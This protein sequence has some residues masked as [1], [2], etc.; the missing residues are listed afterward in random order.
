MNKKGTLA[1]L[2]SMHGQ[3]TGIYALALKRLFKRLEDD[4][5]IMTGQDVAMIK[6]VQTMLKE[7]AIEIDIT[8]KSTS[9]KVVASIHDMMKEVAEEALE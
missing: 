9:R 8:Q 4:D 1:D 3:V 2:E 5:Y 6:N 7:N